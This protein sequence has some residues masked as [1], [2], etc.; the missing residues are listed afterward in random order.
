VDEIF[1]A[2]NEEVELFESDNF[3]ESAAAAAFT[4]FAVELA[5]DRLNR[6]DSIK[7]IFEL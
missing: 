1:L 2:S 4:A 3:E 6:N 5:M 7:L